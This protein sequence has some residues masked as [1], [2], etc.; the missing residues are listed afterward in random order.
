MILQPLVENSIKHGLA[1]KVGG[2][3]ITITTSVPRRP[4]ASS[5]CTTTGSA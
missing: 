4:H 1:R 3:R 2:G 5:K